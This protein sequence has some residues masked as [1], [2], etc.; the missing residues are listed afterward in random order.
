MS[1]ETLIVFSLMLFFQQ[2]ANRSFLFP[3]WYI[4]STFLHELSHYLVALILGGKPT[5]PTIIPKKIGGIW[6][7]GE[8]RLKNPHSIVLL[9]AGLAPLLLL[10]IAYYLTLQPQ[11]IPRDVAIFMLLNA[12][13]PSIEDVRA[14]MSSPQGVLF[15]LAVSIVTYALLSTH[16]STP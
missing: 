10:G 8:V 2:V 1:I 4:F 15:W 6:V 7:L 11:S 9:P 3:L 16:L 13:V 12:S 5:F 14:G